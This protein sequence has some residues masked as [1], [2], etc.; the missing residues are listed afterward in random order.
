[1]TFT[2]ISIPMCLGPRRHAMT[3]RRFWHGA[4]LGLLMA[5]MA[6]CSSER[7]EIPNYNQPTTEGLS[8]DPSAVQLLASGLLDGTRD[9]F[10]GMTRDF[11]ILGAKSTTTSRPMAARLEFSGRNSRA[12]APGPAGFASAT[13]LFRFPKTAQCR[14]AHHGGRGQPGLV[15]QQKS[16]VS[17]FAKTFR[18]LELL[19]AIVSRDTLG[20][21]VDTP[22]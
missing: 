22:A 19:Y 12:S 6:A 8:K 9:G 15:T 4:R 2:Q 16:A 17:G 1:M 11:G 14:P 3:R 10:A 13:G 20:T 18:A 5:G 7:L 21:P